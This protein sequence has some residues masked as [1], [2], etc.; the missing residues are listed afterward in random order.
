LVYGPP[1]MHSGSEGF[2]VV[3]AVRTSN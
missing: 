3:A 1:D 2:R